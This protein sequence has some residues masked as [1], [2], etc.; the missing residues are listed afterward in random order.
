MLPFLLF[1]GS[2]V[3]M[4]IVAWFTHKYIMHGFLWFLHTDHHM[5]HSK[6]FERND[7]FVFMFALPSFFLM[8]FGAQTQFDYRFWIG[9]GIGGYGVL[10]FMFHDILYHQRIK[11][12]SQNKNKYFRTVVKAHGDHHAGKKNYGFLFMFPWKYFRHECN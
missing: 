10:Y 7:F 4:E 8:L 11:L 2:L 6:R 3:F 1:L 12:F 5:M 9:L